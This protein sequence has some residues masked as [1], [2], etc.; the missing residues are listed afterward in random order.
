MTPDEL[1][2]LVEAIAHTLGDDARV[3]DASVIARA[4]DDGAKPEIGVVI[5]GV[6]LVLVVEPV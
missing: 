4:D 5:D 1:N 3:T 6:D 2:E